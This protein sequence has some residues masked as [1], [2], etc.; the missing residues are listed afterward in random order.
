[1]VNVKMC[2]SSKG[3][4]VMF[5]RSNQGSVFGEEGEPVSFCK[6]I[7]F[8]FLIFAVVCVVIVWHENGAKSVEYI[9]CLTDSS[10]QQFSF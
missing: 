9:L 6:N 1:M 2:I 10:S 5:W 3:Y 4:I 7:I 8:V